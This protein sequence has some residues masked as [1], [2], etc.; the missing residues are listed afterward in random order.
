VN[1]VALNPGCRRECRMD[2]T[3]QDGFVIE[4]GCPVHDREGYRP[5]TVVWLN[6]RPVLVGTITLGF[7]G[8]LEDEAHE[9]VHVFTFLS[10]LN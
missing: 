1:K 10:G 2:P 9:H 8:A 4:E 3:V 5:F 7:Y 6:T